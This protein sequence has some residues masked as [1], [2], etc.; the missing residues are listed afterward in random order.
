MRIVKRFLLILACLLALC[1]SAYADGQTGS[2]TLHFNR[3]ETPVAGARFRAYLVA[4]DA[5]SGEYVLTDRYRAYPVDLG[6]DPQALT[7]TL[8]AYIRRDGL[9][10]SADGV[11]DAAG[12]L[13]LT[14]LPEGLYL[15]LGDRVEASGADVIPADCLLS[16]PARH[17]FNVDADVKSEVK[18]PEPPETLVR[19][20]LKIWNDAGH[21]RQRPAEVTAQLLRDGEVYDTVRLSRENNWRHTWDGLDA[22]C[23]WE[24]T[25]LDCPGYTVRAGLSG[26]TFTLTNTYASDT[27]PDQPAKPAAR[28][29][30]T[31]QLWWPV[32]LLAVLGA[33][34]LGLAALRRRK[35]AVWAVLGM[36]LAGCA[37]GLTVS[38]RQE[39]RS[40]GR[41]SADLLG[42][43]TF[44]A[45]AEQ[46][47]PEGQI[48]D[49]VLDPRRDMPEQTVEGCACV[50]KLEIPALSLELPVIS[51]WSYESLEIAPCRYSGSL[52]QN[53]LVIAG[54]NYEAHFGRLRT[55]TLG[56]EVTVTD[57]DGN[58]FR[59]RVSEV[60][61]L[62]PEQ[63]EEMTDSEWDLT[64]F[65][66]T[67]GGAARLAVCCTK[68]E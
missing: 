68:S 24:V 7:E 14:D 65:T 38:N 6:E 48:P 21:E 44:C 12:V 53:D 39:D 36:L 8:A 45:P 5:G 3:N 46:S 51:E 47:L 32:P 37:L 30:Q 49:Y 16:V 18:L 22:S 54:H 9:P 66:C 41:Q 50:A 25:E 31:G 43:L 26:V 20:V 15:I 19:R 64:L 27:P 61:Q 62:A 52:Y 58:R 11:T 17:G 33:L 56:D 42:A 63:V 4:E 28:L 55:L 29:P 34:L 13:I 59:Y 57:L 2:I 60:H 35:A 10:C 1:L 67:V 23:R 40:A